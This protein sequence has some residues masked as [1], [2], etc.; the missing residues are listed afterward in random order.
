MASYGTIPSAAKTKP[1]PF[2][3][4]IPQEK[5][6]QLEQLVKLSPLG[7][8]TYENLF[9]DRRYGISHSWLAKAKKEWESFDWRAHEAHINSF[10]HFKLPV[11]DDDGRKHSVHFVAL[12]STNPSAIPIAFF[13]GWPGSFL[14]FL[15]IL[16]L[17]KSRYKPEELPFHVVVPSLSGYS[18]SDRPPKD[19][20][21]TVSD[22]ARIMDK[23]M[24]EL[25][26]EAGYVAQGGDIGSLIS[27][28]LGAEKESCKAV[29]LNF[30]PTQKPDGVPEDDA[31]ELEKKGLERGSEFQ[32]T[33]FAYAMEHGTRPATIGLVLSSSPIALLSWIGEK[34]LTWT[35]ADPPTLAILESVSL[36]WLTD[37][38][39]TSIWSYRQHFGPNQVPG[40]V[41]GSPKYRLNKPFGFSFFPYELMGVP[42]SWVAANG[43]LV[44]YRQHESGGHFAAMEQPEVLLKDVTDFVQQVWK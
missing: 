5:L 23:F 25:G 19:K 1:T 14:E 8:E 21:W 33:G 43:D 16:S 13:H 12:F 9:E 2:K 44:F 20:D 3:V 32:R 6:Q 36:Y 18:F 31:D 30:S 37:S 41:H 34:F 35:D 27:R 22:E 24:R 11:T 17:L 15:P 40:G 26:F 4:E 38:F 29:H 28:I 39:P 42:K 10:P 7:P